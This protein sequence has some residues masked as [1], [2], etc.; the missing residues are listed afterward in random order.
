[1][2]KYSLL[3]CQKLASSRNGMC[4]SDAYTNRNTKMLWSC[5]NNHKWNATLNVVQKSWCPM[6]AFNRKRSSIEDVMNI[7]NKNDGILCVDMYKNAKQKFTVKCKNNHVFKTD[8]DHLKQENW[9]QKCYIKEYS[10]ADCHKIADNKNGRCISTEYLGFNRPLEWECSSGHRWHV[11]LAHIVN[12]S[13]CPKCKKSKNQDM[14]MDIIKE[15]FSSYNIQK[16]YKGF[17]WL[18][19]K[20]NLEIDIWIP[21]LKMAIEYDG[22]AHFIPVRFSG[23]SAERA[24]KNFIEIQKRD[25]VKDKII[26]Q[27]EEDIKFFLRFNYMEEINKNTILNKLKECGAI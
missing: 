8:Y 23:I 9:C 2:K 6:C 26:K 14:L 20:R 4:L 18:K 27:H 10:I 19:N 7:I 12:G 3:E 17:D 15:I 22:E 11:K 21:D 13:W 1:M 25:K 24:E 5:E 16:N